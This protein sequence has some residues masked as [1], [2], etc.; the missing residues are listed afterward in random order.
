[1]PMTNDGLTAAVE[2]VGCP[3]LSTVWIPDRPDPG[4]EDGRWKCSTCGAE[5]VRAYR[6]FLESWSAPTMSPDGFNR[7]ATLC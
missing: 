4:C 7:A 5:K 1:M 6:P 3:H 2:N